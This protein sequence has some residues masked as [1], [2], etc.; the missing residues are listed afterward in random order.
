MVCRTKSR[1]SRFDIQRHMRTHVHRY[2][3]CIPDRDGGK[4]LR[5]GSDI[6]IWSIQHKSA[7]RVHVI[8]LYDIHECVYIYIYVCV[9]EG[10]C[11]D[12][13]E[14]TLYWAVYMPTHSYLCIY[15]M[16][17]THRETVSFEMDVDR[18]WVVFF[19]Y[20]K[21]WWFGG[22]PGWLKK[23]IMHYYMMSDYILYV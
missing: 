15:I 18:R 20:P 12:D 2:Y 23:Q 3:K 4:G 19:I 17:Q 11:R 21:E 16:Y 6:N 13:C 5:G 8:C 22:H 1:K 10:V 14:K 9:C 7:T